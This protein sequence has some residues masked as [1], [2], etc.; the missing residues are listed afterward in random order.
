MRFLEQ[1]LDD[2]WNW[3][4]KI[5][6]CETLGRFVEQ[7]LESVGV[8]HR[9]AGQQL[10]RLP[11]DPGGQRNAEPGTVVVRQGALHGPA[12]VLIDSPLQPRGAVRLS[13]ACAGDRPA[14]VVNRQNVG[15]KLEFARRSVEQMMGILTE[16]MVAR[17]QQLE[18]LDQARLAESVRAG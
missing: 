14:C 3:F 2:R 9:P 11:E 13:A 8:H 5:S 1:L 15:R 10:G 7:L 6:Q 18:G 12:L 17:E 4:Y 16:V